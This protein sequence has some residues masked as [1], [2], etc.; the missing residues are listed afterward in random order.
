MVS[1]SK[2]IEALH[3]SR[4]FFVPLAGLKLQDEDLSCDMRL[5]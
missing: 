1:G 2:F 5:G 3:H 4:P